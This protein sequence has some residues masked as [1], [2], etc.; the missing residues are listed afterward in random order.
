MQAS[1]E[2]ID[3][4]AATRYKIIYDKLLEPGQTTMKTMHN[5]R[6]HTQAVIEEAVASNVASQIWGK[7][8][9]DVWHAA[10]GDLL[11]F[12]EAALERIMEG[13]FCTDLLFLVTE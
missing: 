9:A 10:K 7:E 11:E 12:R 13:S 8:M 6:K 3:L 4:A 2:V 5:T 1:Q